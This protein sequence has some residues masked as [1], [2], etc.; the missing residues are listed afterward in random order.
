MWCSRV[1]RDPAI[2]N[3]GP[4]TNADL[5]RPGVDIYL[6]KRGLDP[7]VVIGWPPES[8]RILPALNDRFLAKQTSNSFLFLEIIYVSQVMAVKD[9]VEQIAKALVDRPDEVAVRLI[10]GEKS[11]VLQLKVAPDELGKVIGNHGRTFQSIQ[12]ILNA[13]GRKSNKRFVLELTGTN[14]N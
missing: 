6:E 7:E 12:K 10:E 9:L 5:H 4:C 11:T 3:R 13:A 1:R 2:A 8:L 14:S